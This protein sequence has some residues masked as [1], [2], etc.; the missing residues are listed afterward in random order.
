MSTRNAKVKHGSEN[1]DQGKKIVGT[2]H[3]DAGFC[4]LDA[5]FHQQ[6]IHFFVGAIA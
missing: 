2:T 4:T 5:N 6:V 3:G 1:I